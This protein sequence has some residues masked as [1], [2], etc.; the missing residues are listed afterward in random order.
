MKKQW[1]KVLFFD[2]NAQPCRIATDKNKVLEQLLRFMNHNNFGP[3]E[4][5]ILPFTEDEERQ[6][7]FLP[8]L[9]FAENMIPQILQSM[10]PVQ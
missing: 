1:F 2:E 4:V 7:S 9:Y 3:G 10:E 5:H 8:V 6:T